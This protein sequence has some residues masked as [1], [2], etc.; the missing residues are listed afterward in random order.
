M[1]IAQIGSA[2]AA[3]FLRESFQ[4]RHSVSCRIFC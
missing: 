3:T 2:F 4:N 1:R